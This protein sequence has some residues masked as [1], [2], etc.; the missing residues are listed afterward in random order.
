MNSLSYLRFL[1]MF[2]R[3]I[4][5]VPSKHTTR[6]RE[7]KVS[8]IMSEVFRRLNQLEHPVGPESFR[9]SFSTA[10]FSQHSIWFQIAGG[11]FLAGT[12]RTLRMLPTVVIPKTK[13]AKGQQD[14][15]PYSFAHVDSF[16][17]TDFYR[18]HFDQHLYLHPFDMAFSGCCIKSWF[19]L[20]DFS[21][22]RLIF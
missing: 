5:N 9:L 11:E 13:G 16:E 15:P 21:G 2:L 4:S 8:Q 12:T 14:F 20:H 22:H 17:S 1:L 3:T 7:R 18:D 19:R 10:L 6:S